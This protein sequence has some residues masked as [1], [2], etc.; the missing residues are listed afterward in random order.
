MKVLI[1]G[2]GIAG[3]TLAYCLH[4]LGHEPT[5]L[6]RAPELRRGGYLVDFWGAGFDVA[7]HLG[8]VPRLLDLGY[9]IRELREVAE[10]GRTIASIDPLRLVDRLGGRFV[11]IA[12]SD[13]S[14][15]IYDALDG[16]VENVFDDTVT[17]ITDTGDRV[18]VAFRS[19][20]P[21]EFDLV[22]GA[23]GLHSTVRRL[24]F[25]PDTQF[26]KDLGIAIAVFDVG[27]YR[28]RIEGVA[29]TRT[30]IGVQALRLALRDDTTLFVFSFR[31]EGDLPQ[32]DVEA[33]QD[34]LRTRL[35]DVR[36]EV[37]AILGHMPDA[38]TFYLDRAAQ[39]RMPTW[40]RGRVALI[41]DAAACPSFL[42][43]QG[44]ALAMVE[45]Y[46]LAAELHNH[47]G[48]H[49]AAFAAHQSQLAPLVLAK[50]DAAI[51]LGAAF[52]PRN[53]TQIALRLLALKTMGIPV[54]ANI[55]IG[56]SLRDPIT[57]PPPPWH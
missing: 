37:P 5:L 31:F 46:L 8:I 13:L 23:D 54:V 42:A 29:V 36:G 51:S 25:G 45:A 7:D 19:M 16:R 12:R 26:E 35:G 3:P 20:K 18:K 38:N 28:P 4:R 32:E 17:S 6:E 21:R 47:G 11:S 1:V 49:R 22:I 9:R 52:A 40:S 43:G 44:S 14:A 2:A 30:Q 48:D 41:G 57:L 50:Q 34:L 10:N 55:A 56:R 15:A 53:R 24:T 33:Q 27:G 39:I